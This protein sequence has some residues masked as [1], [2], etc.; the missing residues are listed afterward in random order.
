MVIINIKLTKSEYDN[1]PAN[2]EYDHTFS[3]N[4]RENENWFDQNTVLGNSHQARTISEPEEMKD[5][6]YTANMQ[7]PQYED[8]A[9][10]LFNSYVNL[11]RKNVKLAEDR[12]SSGKCLIITS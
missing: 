9:R 7:T 10:F 3:K 4:S 11:L 6:E 8:A 12:E 1:L 5:Y 2:S